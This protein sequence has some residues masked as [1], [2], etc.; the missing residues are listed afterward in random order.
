M[1]AIIMMMIFFSFVSAVVGAAWIIIQLIKANP[2]AA[3]DYFAADYRVRAEK[4]ESAMQGYLAGFDKG[5]QYRQ[6]QMSQSQA[7]HIL[8]PPPPL[9]LN[10][11]ENELTP[12]N[13]VNVPKIN[14]GQGVGKDYAYKFMSPG[15]VWF[16]EVGTVPDSNNVLAILDCNDL[17][18]AGKAEKLGLTELYAVRCKCGTVKVSTQSTVT[19]CSDNCKTINNIK[20]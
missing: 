17:H 2:N 12:S 18:Q 7:G 5:L 6:P 1:G 14:I 8:P 13:A 15:V 9:Q 20:K 3:V 19:H 4:A 10:E 11:P 16:A